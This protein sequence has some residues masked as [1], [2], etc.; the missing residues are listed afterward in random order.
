MAGTRVWRGGGKGRNGCGPPERYGCQGVECGC[1]HDG[2][3]TPD[4]LETTPNQTQ[5]ETFRRQCYLLKIRLT[6]IGS[7]LISEEGNHAWF[8]QVTHLFGFPFP[9]LQNRF[10]DPVPSTSQG[11]LNKTCE[12]LQKKECKDVMLKALLLWIRNTRAREVIAAKWT[13]LSWNLDFPTFRLLFFPCKELSVIEAE[14]YGSCQKETQQ[15]KMIEFLISRNLVLEGALD[16]TY[17]WN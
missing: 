1:P 8:S 17:F 9:N 16:N 15:S 4:L 2:S 5:R 14:G 11:I 7:D 13:V 10:H 6:A 3:Q 12:S